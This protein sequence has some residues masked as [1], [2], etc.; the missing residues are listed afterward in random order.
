MKCRND[1]EFA[2]STLLTKK[3]W[4]KKRMIPK[5]G[6]Q[7]TR[8][9][10]NGF[11]QERNVYYNKEEV[12]PMSDEELKPIKEENHRKYLRAKEREREKR[13]QKEEDLIY[14][15]LNDL[16]K[17][18]LNRCAL[19]DPIPCVNPTGIIVLDVETTG[20]DLGSEVLQISVIDWNGKT[21]INEYVH[22]YW[23]T[24]WESAQAIHG[25]SPKDVED[26]PYPHELV[27]K[28]KGIIDSAKLIVGY[29]VNF[30]LAFIEQW[31]IKTEDKEI[32]DVMREFAPIYGDWDEY[33]QSYRWKKLI[34]CADY[35]GY[36][37][38]AHDSLEDVKATLYCYKKM[39]GEL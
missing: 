31:G 33:H 14:D 28:V 36:E 37:F 26:A 11:R 38:K 8:L 32:Y 16:G 1:S 6:E 12:R 13:A 7:G 15:A 23:N 30:D 5:E 17:K 20:L 24:H 18:I 39:V 25:I 2:N 3:Q 4:A 22:P 9:W 21:L 34:C 35:Y 10:T 19:I 29:N 27:A